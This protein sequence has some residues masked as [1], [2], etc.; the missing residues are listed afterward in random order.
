MD[1]TCMGAHR[2]GDQLCVRALCSTVLA[3]KP[4]A[5]SSVDHQAPLSLRLAGPESAEGQA[6]HRHSAHDIRKTGSDLTAQESV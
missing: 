2:T 6:T 3:R 4:V 5:W 1:Q